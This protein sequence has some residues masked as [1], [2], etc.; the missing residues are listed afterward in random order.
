MNN[1][2]LLASLIA[3]NGLSIV[4]ILKNL[5]KPV[6]P[7]TVKEARIYVGF[8]SLVIAILLVALVIGF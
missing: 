8:H 1:V 7:M 2:P 5:G 4:A 6:K 3:F